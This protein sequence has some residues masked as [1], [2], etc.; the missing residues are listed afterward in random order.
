MQAETAPAWR[1]WRTVTPPSPLPV[2]AEEQPMG[3]RTLRRCHRGV[4]VNWSRVASA[5]RH[6][7]LPGKRWG[8]PFQRRQAGWGQT[9]APALRLRGQCSYRPSLPTQGYGR[10][11]AGRA[12]SW[13]APERRTA[14]SCA[15]RLTLY[16]W[17]AQR[18]QGFQPPPARIMEVRWDEDSRLEMLHRIKGGCSLRGRA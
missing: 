10:R 11:G 8:V 16:P 5:G 2:G 12:G 7:R 18:S 14:R 4:G 9:S 15:G 1:A 13:V 3:Q 17:C 6:Q